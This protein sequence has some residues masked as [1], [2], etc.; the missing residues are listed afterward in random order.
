MAGRRVVHTPGWLSF[1]ERERI[2]RG[3][4]AGE[5]DSEIA[6]A[7]GRHRVDGRARDRAGC[8]RRRGY[9]ASGGRARVAWRRGAAA[10]G[11]QARRV[12]RG[13][14]RRSRQGLQRRW[15]PQQ[16]SAQTGARVSRSMA[17]MRISHERS[18]ARC[19]PVARRAAPPAEREPAPGRTRRRAGAARDAR[20]DRRTWSR[21]PSARRGRRPRRSRPLGRR[22]A[23]SA[24]AAG[25]RS[26]RWSSARPATCCG[27][28]PTAARRSR[29]ID[30]LQASA[31]SDAAGASG[32]SL[33]LGPGR[34]N[35]PP[36]WRFTDRRPASRSSS[37]T[38]THR[39]SA[40]PTKT[41]TGCCASTCRASSIWL[42]AARSTLTRS[43]PNST[44]DPAR[45]CNWDTPAEKMHELVVAL[46]RLT[47]RPPDRE[48]AEV[49]LRPGA[50][51]R[52]RDQGVT[53]R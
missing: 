53:R 32:R 2:S 52:D 18:I 14:W 15:S 35:W 5:S 34:A 17:E 9:R 25:R 43:P 22:S 48:L 36:T 37:A 33:D 10:Q 40:G 44:A 45:P 42:R 11:D 20:P 19:C 12:R 41:P 38:R 50:T 30:A 23:C 1:E 4:A 47:P 28:L 3:I 26:R 13:C 49:R 8:G 39:G 16:I 51:Q 24:P 29:S 31:S 27:R 7:L 46:T 6:R 21:S